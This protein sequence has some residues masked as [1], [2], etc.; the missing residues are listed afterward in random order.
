MNLPQS[1]FLYLSRRKPLVFARVV[2]WKGWNVIQMSAE[3]RWKICRS[4]VR[5]CR[6]NSKVSP[7]S[8]F[9]VVPAHN[10]E[11]VARSSIDYGYRTPIV[12][13][14]WRGSCIPHQR[15]MFIKLKAKF[16]NAGRESELAVVRDK[17][18]TLA[19]CEC[20]YSQ[21]LHIDGAVLKSSKW[22]KPASEELAIIFQSTL[23][24]ASFSKIPEHK[25]SL[26]RN[27]P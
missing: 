25:T 16:F 1:T 21:E 10:A 17:D 7:F 9:G 11:N 3:S 15:D 13:L 8:F 6:M 5:F 12:R 27:S 18:W 24:K 22:S 20:C 26:H 19:G 14:V 23:T 2:F 4:P